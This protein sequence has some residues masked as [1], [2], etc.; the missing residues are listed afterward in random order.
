ML[1]PSKAFRRLSLFFIVA[2]VCIACAPEEQPASEDPIEAP[3]FVE[4]SAAL[5]IDFTH[6]RAD[7][8]R[9]YF[10]EIM[11]GGAAWIDYDMDGFQDL[12]LVQGGASDGSRR[13]AHGNVLF[14]NVEGTRFEDVTEMAGVGG[15]GIRYGNGRRRLR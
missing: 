4:S 13:S 8:V 14:K 5:G 11:S 10:P 9:Y 12:Y 2:T 7:E 6:V 15:Y 1:H 3:W